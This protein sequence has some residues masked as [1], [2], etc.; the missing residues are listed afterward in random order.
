MRRCDVVRVGIV[1]LFIASCGGGGS[2]ST[3]S[4]SSLLPDEGD[5]VFCGGLGTSS[6]PYLICNEAQFRKINDDPS[7]SYKLNQDIYLTSEITP[8]SSLTGTFDGNQKTVYDIEYTDLVGNDA[9][10]ILANNGVIH[11][12]RFSHTNF[13]GYG[14]RTGLVARN[15]GALLGVA[16]TDGAVSAEYADSTGSLGGIVADNYGSIDNC[17]FQGIILYR[18][19]VTVGGVVGINRAGAE[20]NWAYLDE[21]SSISRYSGSSNFFVGGIVGTNLGT[22]QNAAMYSGAIVADGSNV[23]GIAG[24]NSAGAVID[25]A[26]VLGTVKSNKTAGALGGVAAINWGTIKK[27]VVTESTV[28]DP[29]SATGGSVGGVVGYQSSTA[30]IE[31][32]YSLA[33]IAASGGGG[34][35]GGGL[36][37]D[38]SGIIRRSY[39]SASVGSYTYAGAFCG[40]KIAGSST[41]DS[42]F[43]SGSTPSTDSCA[44]SKTGAQ[45]ASQATFTGW[46]FVNVW[47]I[48]AGEMPTL[49]WPDTFPY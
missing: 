29:L 49:R 5:S 1:A 44:T 45:L 6:S 32:S 10:W 14:F 19:N 17:G 22:I 40:Y 27:A 18:A 8:I 43:Y 37:G 16:V 11:S 13:Y 35:S 36:V 24:A 2:G 26:A 30:V 38:Q 12:V 31:D 34:S 7:A 48:S 23:G 25:G 39:S 15:N 4:L 46:D 41:T 3:A 42:Y 28:I 9:G 33:T 47:K 20:V 21:N